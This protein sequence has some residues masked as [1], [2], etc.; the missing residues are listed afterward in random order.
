[1]FSNGTEQPYQL[2]TRALE[3]ST[4]LTPSSHGS[5]PRRGSIVP[6]HNVRRLSNTTPSSSQVLKVLIL[7][8]EEVAS[9][10]SAQ[11]KNNVVPKVAK[12]MRRSVSYKIYPRQG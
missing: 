3:H 8:L 6:A 1:M 12:L 4:F 7:F 11:H 9:R 5:V 2:T 10:T